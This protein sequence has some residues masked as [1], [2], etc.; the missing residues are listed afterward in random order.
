MTLMLTGTW[1]LA[2]TILL[3]TV[4]YIAGQIPMIAVLGPIVTLGPLAFI[5][6]LF[7]EKE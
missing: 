3:L 7:A 1:I 4:L 5:L 2:A 6:M